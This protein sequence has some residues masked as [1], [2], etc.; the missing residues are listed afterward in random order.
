MLPFPYTHEYN[1]P[2]CSV[3]ITNIH[4]AEKHCLN[5][6]HILLKMVMVP[7]MSGQSLRENVCQIIKLEIW[8]RHKTHGILKW[9]NFRRH[10]TGR[11]NQFLILCWISKFAHLQRNEQFLIFNILQMERHKISQQT[12]KSVFDLQTKQNLV[13]DWENIVAKHSG[14]R[15]PAVVHWVCTHLMKYFGPL[16]TETLDYLGFLGAAWKLRSGDQLRPLIDLDM[17]FLQSRLCCLN[18][19]FWVIFILEDPV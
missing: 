1:W 6:I 14:K 2:A 9:N 13:L 7:N 5:L 17:L 3:V 19:M 10:H 12:E 16:F 18:N 11:G 4:Y 8:C 15:F